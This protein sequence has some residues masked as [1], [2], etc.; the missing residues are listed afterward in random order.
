[1]AARRSDKVRRVTPHP[2]FLLAELLIGL[3]IFT[4]LSAAAL[5]SC[6]DILERYLDKRSNINIEREVNELSH[7][8]TGVLHRSVMNRRDF[9]ITASESSPT[10]II[11]VKWKNISGWEEWKGDDCA[12]RSNSLS[13]H[14]NSFVYKHTTQ[15]LT[16]GFELI[17]YVKNGSRWVMTDWRI[18][19][20]PYG[21]VRA[22]RR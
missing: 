16:P 5:V 21:Y 8:L 13:G 11:Q 17:F 14:A 6:T 19:V 12:V 15:T 3:T 10:R 9:T 1:M 20:S 22:Y 7:W 4:V 18:S 2:A